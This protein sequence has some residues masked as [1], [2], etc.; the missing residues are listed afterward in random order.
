MSHAILTIPNPAQ[1][2]LVALVG[3]TA[4]TIEELTGTTLAPN[5]AG[6]AVQAEGGRIRWTLDGSA[7]VASVRGFLLD[8]GDMAELSGAEA[9][10]A[11]WVA[12]TGTAVLQV[13]GYST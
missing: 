3:S 8:A 7:P 2:H 1:P 9:A 6:I 4:G 11:R 5:N 10:V 12:E 13:G